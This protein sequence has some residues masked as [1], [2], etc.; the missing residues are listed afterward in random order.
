MQTLGELIKKERKNSNMT[1]EKL[2]ET[3]GV[4]HSYIAKIEGGYQGASNKT[5]RKLADALQIDIV[6]LYNTDPAFRS[7]TAVLYNETGEYD[8]KFKK[9]HPKIK[10]MLLDLAPTLKKYL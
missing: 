6:E 10:E 1:Q 9:L 5:L 4:T 8:R 7:D 3:I 2:A